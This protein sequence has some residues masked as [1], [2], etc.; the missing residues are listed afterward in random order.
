MGPTW[1][2]DVEIPWILGQWKIPGF[3]EI[4]IGDFAHIYIY[5]HHLCSYHVL[6]EMHNYKNDNI[7]VLQNGC[8]VDSRYVVNPV[9]KHGA[10][11]GWGVDLSPSQV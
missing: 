10:V 11:N 7:S 1:K 5:K 4:A 2:F 9:R 3:L 8:S 6:E